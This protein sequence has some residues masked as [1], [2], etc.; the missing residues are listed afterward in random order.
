MRRELLLLSVALVLSAGCSKE[1]SES[2]AAAGSSAVAKTEAKPP[3]VAPFAERLSAR[4]TVYLL[5]P[6]QLR[7]RDMMLT[8]EKFK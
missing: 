7:I 4:L 5:L 6:Q 2:K 1:A 8:L 3:E